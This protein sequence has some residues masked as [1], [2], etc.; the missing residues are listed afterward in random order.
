MK[1]SV[2]IHKIKSVSFAVTINSKFFIIFLKKSLDLLIPGFGKKI[3]I[4]N[5]KQVST[6][7]TLVKWA[8]KNN[9]VSSGFLKTEFVCIF[10]KASLVF[11]VCSRIFHSYGDVTIANRHH[12]RWVRGCKIYTYARHLR[13][14]SREGSCLATPTCRGA[15]L[16]FFLSHPKDRPKIKWPFRKARGSGDL[17]LPVSPKDKGRLR[18]VEHFK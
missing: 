16:G 1:C 14:Y 4:E 18:K 3:I 10:L 7:F 15:G 11:K 13:S 12:C 5:L 6:W 17:F 8:S 2:V 9:N